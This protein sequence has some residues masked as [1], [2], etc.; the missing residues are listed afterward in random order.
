MQLL[1]VRSGQ[2]FRQCSSV[3]VWLW[4]G[5]WGFFCPVTLGQALNLS[6]P[7]IRFYG[8]RRRG[9]DHI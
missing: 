9:G 8:V 7:Q 2:G 5:I 6:G 4:G 3:G 1:K